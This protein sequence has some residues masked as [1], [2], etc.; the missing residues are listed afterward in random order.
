M[1]L[2]GLVLNII[3]HVA[4]SLAYEFGSIKGMAYSVIDLRE[5]RPCNL[6]RTTAVE[7]AHFISK[8]MHVKQLHLTIYEK[9]DDFSHMIAAITSGVWFSTQTLNVDR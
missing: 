6:S 5:R 9:K 7:H 8:A 3:Q 1:P 2:L 4:C